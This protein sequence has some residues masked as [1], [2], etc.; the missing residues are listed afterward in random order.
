MAVLARSLLL[1]RAA[2]ALPSGSWGAAPCRLL[3]TSI[4]QTRIPKDR[5]ADKQNLF[6]VL[7][8]Q[9]MYGVG[10]IVYR[11]SWAEKGYAPETHH[12]RITR[13]KDF[14]IVRPP[15]PRRR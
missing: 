11:T 10:S 1:R 12:W 4:E 3:C 2:A 8:R 7:V 6:D 15:K 5:P 9:P 13:T 14:K